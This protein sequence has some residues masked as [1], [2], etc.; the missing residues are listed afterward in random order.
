MVMVYDS[1]NLSPCFY[2]GI[3]VTTVAKMGRLR[4]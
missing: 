1:G 4:M 3:S 2:A